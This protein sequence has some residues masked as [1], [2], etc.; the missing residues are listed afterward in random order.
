MVNS[1]VLETD[2]DFKIKLGARELERD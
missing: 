1:L 2:L